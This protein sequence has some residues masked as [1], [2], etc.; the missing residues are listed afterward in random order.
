MNST[1]TEKPAGAAPEKKPARWQTAGP[2]LIRYRSSGQYFAR[3]RV[4]GKLIVRSLKTNRITVARLRLADTQKQ[5]R[6]R[7]EHLTSAAAAN[8][9]LTFG[10]ALA[11]YRRRLDG[12]LGLKPRTKE[13][14]GERIAALIKSWPGLEKTDAARIT[15]SACLDWAAAY[16]KKR[17]STNFNNTV[18]VL[19][20]VLEIAVESGARYDNPARFI[21]RVPER[22][23]ERDLPSPKQYEKLLQLIKHRKAAN[24]VRFLVYGGFRVSEAAKITWGD[25]DLEKGT[26]RVRGDEQTATKN[27]EIR[28]RPMIPEMKA[29]LEALQAENPGRKPTDRVIEAKEC[30]GSLASACEQLGIQKLDHH[31]LRHLFST[32]SVESGASLPAV[33]KLLGH[34]DGGV[35][36]AKRYNHVSDAHLADAAER[37][38]VAAPAPAPADKVTIPAADYA[39]LVAELEAFRKAAA[40]APAE[41][42]PAT[43]A[44]AQ[45][46]G[47]AE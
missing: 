6:Q 4:R 30:R 31:A 16:G 29:F 10:D 11:I 22:F 5:E 44:G 18:G 26:I 23:K 42:K 9:K 2:N 21:K 35:L 36:L 8:G 12:N 14:Y 32:R 15:K 20:W 7:A 39:G 40:P 47:H 28:K 38:R 34:K 13:Y 43:D 45:P 24:L 17:S 33:A 27:W 46:E 41:P 19:K 37:I 3:L 25:V 1:A